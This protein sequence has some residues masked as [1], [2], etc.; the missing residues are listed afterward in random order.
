M[1]SG[2]RW[3]FIFVVTTVILVMEMMDTEELRMAIMVMMMSV[4][5]EERS[6]IERER[7]GRDNRRNTLFV[8]AVLN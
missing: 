6:L 5:K 4:F 2:G 8:E 1:V 7:G 3:S